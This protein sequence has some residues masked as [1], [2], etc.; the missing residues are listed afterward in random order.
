MRLLTIGTLKGQLAAA[1]KIAADSGASAI[2]ADCI[3]TATAMLRSGQGA[4]LLMVD[5][6][7]DICDLVVQ[8]DCHR[9]RCLGHQP[10][11]SPPRQ[12]FGDDAVERPKHLVAAGFEQGLVKDLVGQ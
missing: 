10:V 9:V 6:A 5:I 8:L 2:H 3:D 12:H 1:A 7:I 11:M 4:D